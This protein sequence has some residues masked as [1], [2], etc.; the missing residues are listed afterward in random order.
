MNQ[1]M[2]TEQALGTAELPA[3]PSGSVSREG[4]RL[5][6][7][8]ANFRA[9]WAAKVRDTRR[10]AAWARMRAVS[11][12]RIARDVRIAGVLIGAILGAMN[13]AGGH[14]FPHLL[15]GGLWAALLGLPIVILLLF[16]IEGVAGATHL[17][18]E[19]LERAA[20]DLER[21]VACEELPLATIRGATPESVS[22]DSGDQDF[23]ETRAKFRAAWS[24][25]LAGK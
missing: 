18:A 15:A 3:P 9:A 7:A 8:R 24:A 6:E 1:T 17:K 22:A 12:H 5:D 4:E 25:R 2:I 14:G 20:R 16:L 21:Q 11:L 10:Q 23:D 19:R 13:L